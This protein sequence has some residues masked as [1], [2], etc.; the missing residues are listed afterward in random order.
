MDNKLSNAK[1]KF[2][3]TVI[4]T[5]GIGAGLNTTLHCIRKSKYS[6]PQCLGLG[7]FASGATSFIIKSGVDYY[8]NIA[9]IKIT[10]DN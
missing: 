9:D 6:T 4:S 8:N 10:S 2:Q 7:I 5:F 3:N 1:R